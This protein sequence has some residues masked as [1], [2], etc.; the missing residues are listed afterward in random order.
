[1]R[2]QAAFSM[3][4][5]IFWRTAS[6]GS[7]A[8]SSMASKRMMCQP[9]R[10]RT[11]STVTSP[12][13]SLRK[14]AS[15]SDEVS[16]G[17]TW[18]SFPPVARELQSLSDA[19][20]REK[21]CGLSPT[22]AASSR[23]RACAMVRLLS[24]RGSQAT[25]MCDTSQRGGVRKRD[26]S[27]S[28]SVRTACSVGESSSRTV[29]RSCR[30][31]ASSS[32]SNLS[33]PTSAGSGSSPCRL[34]SC[35]RS[36]RT[37]KALAALRQANPGLPLGAGWFCASAAMAA[38]GT[39]SP[40]TTRGGNRD[41]VIAVT[42]PGRR[43]RRMAVPTWIS[44]WLVLEMQAGNASAAGCCGA[45]ARPGSRGVSTGSGTAPRSLTGRGQVE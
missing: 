44:P 8:P 42:R 7:T 45:N 32:V 40:F 10:V 11:G 6:N 20:I 43:Q 17:P 38:C 2:T 19:A 23:A 26:G 39:V 33:A 13:E 30:I 41:A 3:A 21:S 27:R 5:D 16:P 29:S 1:M 31:K 35:K 36:V 14:A 12:S 18:P 24:S 15:N 25:R 34:A 22:R 28:H 9:C 37:A 4:S